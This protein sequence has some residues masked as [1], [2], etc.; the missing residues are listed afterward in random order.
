MA[1][2]WHHPQHLRILVL[3]QT[4][5]ARGVNNIPRIAVLV[6]LEPWVRVYHALVEPHHHAGIGILVIVLRHEY[7]TWQ[8]DAAVGGGGGGGGLGVAAA[9]VAAAQVGGEEECG[10]EEEEG[11]GYG[12]GVAEAEVGEVIRGHGSE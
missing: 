7:D 10:E 11:E 6:K 1:A 4:Y 12:D 8:D 5:G 3:A 9:V 2:L